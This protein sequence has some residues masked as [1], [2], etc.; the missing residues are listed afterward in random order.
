MS[1][2]VE[3]SLVIKRTLIYCISKSLNSQKKSINSA[4][5]G[6]TALF[7]QTRNNLRLSLQSQS[8]VSGRV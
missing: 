2:Q 6:G 8:S 5:T 7:T 4:N 1:R 3:F